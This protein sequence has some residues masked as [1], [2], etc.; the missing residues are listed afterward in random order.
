VAWSDV[1]RWSTTPTDGRPWCCSFESER[2]V[3]FAWDETYVDVAGLL[4][5]Q[6][7]IWASKVRFLCAGSYATWAAT[8]QT[9]DR[10]LRTGLLAAMS[11][12]RHWTLVAI[13]QPYLISRACPSTLPPFSALQ[14]RY[15][16][17]IEQHPR[18]CARGEARVA[19]R[20]RRKAEKAPRERGERWALWGE[21]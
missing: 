13:V 1:E 11:F 9:H 14:A 20:L 15:T 10:L 12:D 19:L 3:L 7:D 16:L 6:H 17:R 18:D 2:E 21:L 4:L 5:Y 8:I